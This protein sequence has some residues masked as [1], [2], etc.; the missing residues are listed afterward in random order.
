MVFDRLSLRRGGMAQDDLLLDRFCPDYDATTTRHVIVDAPVGVTY[1][2]IET[3]DLTET[4]LVTRVLGALRLLPETVR[5]LRGRDV[6]EAMPERVTFGDID[7]ADGWV[8][9]GSEADR[10]FVFGAVGRFWQPTI[11]WHDVDAEAFAD[12]AEPGWAKIGASISV[13]PYGR[14]RTLL[15][16]EA[17]TATT[18]AD[19]HSRFGRYWLVV[20]PFAGYVMGRALARIA[21][22]AETAYAMADGEAADVESTG[23]EITIAQ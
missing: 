8:R 17:R 9:L 16:F 3:A 15:T 12:F 19:A 4:G 6:T 20:G 5:T 18:D 23:T 7:D 22:D 10:E 13:R 1:Q 2:A 21:T 14:E 11:E